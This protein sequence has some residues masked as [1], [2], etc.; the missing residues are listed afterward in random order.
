MKLRSSCA[1]WSGPRSLRHGALAAHSALTVSSA[2]SQLVLHEVWLALSCHESC[3]G[4]AKFEKYQ[5]VTNRQLSAALVLRSHGRR[6]SRN[7]V[8]LAKQGTAIESV[9]PSQYHSNL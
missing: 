4:L 3:S 6:L 9:M 2:P 1:R 5:H 7:Q 8:A